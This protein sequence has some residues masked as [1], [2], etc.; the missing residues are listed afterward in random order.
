MRTNLKK[1]A[2]AFVCVFAFGTTACADNEK[3]INF[4]QLPAAAQ[5]FVKQYFASARVALTQ[6]ESGILEKNYDVTFTNGDKVEFDRK[7]QWTE[8]TAATA[9]PTALVP[10]A[11]AQ[12]IKT[13]YAGTTVRNIE[14]D[15]R[16]YDVKLSNG[17]ELTFNTKFQLVDIDN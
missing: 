15:G 13:N 2:L 8:I 12:Y 3:P 11:I 7:G 10:Q 14:R 1:M 4:N 5:Q 17:M 9:V 16:E 6:Q